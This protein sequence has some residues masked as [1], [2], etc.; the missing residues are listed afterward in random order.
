MSRKK[1]V[2]LHFNVLEKYPPA[3]NFIADA[4]A[5]K[6][7]HKISVITSLNNSPYNN[8][9]FPGV[10]ILRLGSTSKNAVLRY[11]S[12]VTYNFIG[13]LV[14]LIKRPEVVLVY[15]T[16]SI[17][18]AFIYSLVFPRKKIHI[19]YHEYISLP[20]KES[21][22]RYMKVLFKCEDKILRKYTCSQTNEDRKELFF[23][24]NAKLKKQ[25]VFVFP[26]MPPESWWKDF[27]QI[28]KPWDNG[29]IKLVYVGVLDAETMY[30][31]EVLRWVSKQ[32]NK[33]ELTLYS[34]DVSMSAA[35]IIGQYGEPNIFLKPA[36]NYY[37]LPKELINYDIGLVLYKGHIP[38]YIYNV[39]NK[40]YEYLFC[41]LKVI[42]DSSLVSIKKNIECD[43]FSYNLKQI[44]KYEFDLALLAKKNKG[45]IYNTP[46]LINLFK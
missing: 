29:K 9:T 7:L 42:A 33:L 32:S 37:S 28:K 1:L 19:H 12:Y 11:A 24:D 27:G 14:L 3:L 20:E 41:G 43:I 46:S 45:Q 6:I 35:N 10:K 17:F 36:L 23:K 40:V 26:N 2:I 16:L 30:L 44:E 15:E 8:Q 21:A 34:Q 13:T 22:S 4:L 38:N 18:P 39:P 31:E 5:Q 25:N